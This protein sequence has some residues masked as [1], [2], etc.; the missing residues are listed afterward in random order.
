MK[1]FA[2][3]GFYSILNT[4]MGEKMVLCSLGHMLHEDTW[5]TCVTQTHTWNRGGHVGMGDPWIHIH[6]VHKNR[7]L[8]ETRIMCM[9]V[10]AC[11][12]MRTRECDVNTRPLMPF[13]HTKEKRFSPLHHHLLYPSPQPPA[14]LHVHN[15][16]MH[17]MHIHS[18]V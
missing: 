16:H 6:T 9:C 11:G 15:N 17:C 14:P 2:P 7:K 12:C 18:R 8:K 13:I 10:R 3:V 1:P 5:S 4:C